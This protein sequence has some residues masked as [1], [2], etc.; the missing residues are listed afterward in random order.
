MYFIYINYF[1]QII[2]MIKKINQCTTVN[3][4]FYKSDLLD[5]LFDLAPSLTF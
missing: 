4:R 1:N 3:E 5:L 2:I